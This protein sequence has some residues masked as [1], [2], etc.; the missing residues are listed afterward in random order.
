LG[1]PLSELKQMF[2]SLDES[3]LAELALVVKG[4]EN[5]NFDKELNDLLAKYNL[6]HIHDAG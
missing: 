3:F 5:Q 1:Q 2:C 6:I 4:M